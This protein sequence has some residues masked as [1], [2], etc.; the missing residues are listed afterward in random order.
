MTSSRD[1]YR[2]T[3][4]CC[5]LAA[6]RTYTFPHSYLGAVYCMHR[7]RRSSPLN[8][9]KVEKSFRETETRLSQ[10]DLDRLSKIKKIYYV[11]GHRINNATKKHCIYN[12]INVNYYI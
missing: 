9:S 3:G 1:D 8:F 4:P 2:S 5:K 12:D 11:L 6:L 10:E 7:S